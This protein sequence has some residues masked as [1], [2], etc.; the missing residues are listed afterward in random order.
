MCASEIPTY[1]YLIRKWLIRKQVSYLI[2]SEIISGL[3]IFF[4][5]VT[6]CVGACVGL[7]EGSEGA[8][9]GEHEP[10]LERLKA[11]ERPSGAAGVRP[12]LVRRRRFFSSSARIAAPGGAQSRSFFKCPL[13]HRQP[14]ALN[15]RS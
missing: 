10:E 5:G 12:D 15:A 8:E 7:A 11:R 1:R 6:A 4:A 13:P 9:G 14:Q 2:L 3:D